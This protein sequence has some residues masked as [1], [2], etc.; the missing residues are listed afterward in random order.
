MLHNIVKKYD[1]FFLDN[2]ELMMRVESSLRTMLFLS[3]GRLRD[4]EL[5]LEAV[6]TLIGI[7]SWYHD[8][9]LVNH[10]QDNLNK[11]Q[12]LHVFQ[13]QRA[14]EFLK[15]VSHSNNS[16]MPPNPNTFKPPVIL[17][18][19]E[20]IESLPPKNCMSNAKWLTLIRFVELLFEMYFRQKWGTQRRWMAI[21]CVELFK[22]TLKLSVLAKTGWQ[23]LPFHFQSLPQFRDVTVIK[24]ILNAANAM[25]SSPATEQKLDGSSKKRSRISVSRDKLEAFK[26]QTMN[27]NP[28]ENTLLA[29][30]NTA[31]KIRNP[32][33]KPQIIA[34]LLH[35]VRPII[36]VLAMIKFGDKTWKPW[37]IS[38]L[39]DLISLRYYVQSAKK[40]DD[41]QADEAT[42]RISLL[43][44]YLL[45]SPAFEGIMTR[46][47]GKRQDTEPQ[48]TLGRI[49]SSA[50]EYLEAYQ[51]H[52]FYTAAT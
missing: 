24:D 20:V 48:S 22:A 35:I 52:Y 31:P 36:Y 39:T 23:T 6:Y 45:R 3:P 10:L 15:Q 14:Q 42:R 32:A 33:S 9:V 16:P 21:L 46:L 28:T 30:T 8:V 19:S 1:K 43:G 26:N 41:V 12:Q 37:L 27:S 7:I 29:A 47:L 40:L 44:Y 34:E 13:V 11:L 51:D 5:K 49:V 38:L 4:S 25:N 2:L 18:V 17:P 50:R